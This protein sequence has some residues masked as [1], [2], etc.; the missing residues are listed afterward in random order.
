[1]PIR[2]EQSEIAGKHSSEAQLLYLQLII[3]L[4]TLS[5]IFLPRVVGIQPQWLDHPRRF[6]KGSRECRICTAR[7]GLIRKYNIMI[8]R[9]CFRE[10]AK[11]IGFVKYR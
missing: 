2:F 8:C 4:N 11:E 9:R 10:N 6:G 1:L 5:P 3:E 7:Q